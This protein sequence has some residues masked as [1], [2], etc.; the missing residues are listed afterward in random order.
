MPLRAAHRH[1]ARADR[2]HRRDHE[3]A[4]DL[5]QV[6]NALD[7]ERLL[8]TERRAPLRRRPRRPPRIRKPT[9]HRTAVATVLRGHRTAVATVLLRLHLLLL[10]HH[11][12][13]KAAPWELL[14]VH[15]VALRFVRALDLRQLL[16]DIDAI[17]ASTV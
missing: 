13:V 11:A 2:E 10:L 15:R 3:E 17:S 4:V 7:T 9:G 6:T 16:L 12:H 8:L 1:H 5:A 14:D